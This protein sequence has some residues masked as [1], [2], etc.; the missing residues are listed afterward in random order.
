MILE[1]RL[2][3]AQPRTIRVGYLY[4]NRLRRPASRVP[5]IRLAGQWLGDAGF[6]EGDTLTIQVTRGEIR[7]IRQESVTATGPRPKRFEDVLEAG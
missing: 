7:L 1:E 3:E 5:F 4:Q 6:N 2:L